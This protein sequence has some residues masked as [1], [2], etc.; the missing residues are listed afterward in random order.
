MER[1]Y[2]KLTGELTMQTLTKIN[3]LSPFGV[4]ILSGMVFWGGLFYAIIS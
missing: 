4:A 2:R 3:G 1:K